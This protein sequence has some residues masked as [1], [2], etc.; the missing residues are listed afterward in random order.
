[1]PTKNGLE[2]LKE[3][4]SSHPH[5]PVII[6]SMHPEGQYASRALRAGAS[7]YITK[8]RASED[9]VSAVRKVYLK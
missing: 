1:M 9:L 8:E 3:L 2:V 4:R 7:A 5:I 6:L